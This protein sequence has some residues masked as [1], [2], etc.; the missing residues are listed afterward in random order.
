MATLSQISALQ[1]KEEQVA[2]TTVDQPPS[3]GQSALLSR[4]NRVE[5][6][7]DALNE[8][9]AENR[10]DG[11]LLRRL[12]AWQPTQTDPEKTEADTSDEPTSERIVQIVRREQTPVNLNSSS[13]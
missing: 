13:E 12:L 7:L 6:D 2:E 9:R 8:T 1:P 5:R 3:A 4:T 10:I 11:A